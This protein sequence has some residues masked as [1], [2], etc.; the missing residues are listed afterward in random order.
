M[1][2]QRQRHASAFCN[3]PLKLHFHIGTA[4]ARRSSSSDEY[5]RIAIY[6][7]LFRKLSMRV[8]CRRAQKSA[9]RFDAFDVRVK[10]YSRSAECEIFPLL[11]EIGIIDKHSSRA[12]ASSRRKPGAIAHKKKE[13]R[14]VRK[15]E[16]L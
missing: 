13:Q 5:S 1:A 8:G 10:N 7:Y 6:L 15:Q 11:Y 4:N 2:L 12:R 9:Q 14:Y 3:I 16:G